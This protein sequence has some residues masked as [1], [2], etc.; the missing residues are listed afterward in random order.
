MS[1]Y[2]HAQ[3]LNIALTGLMASAIQVEA[4]VHAD[5]PVNTTTYADCF[6]RVAM[7]IG[8]IASLQEEVVRIMTDTKQTNVT[9]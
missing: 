3:R 1:L 8:H 4:L 9:Q 7:C 6:E 5:I 2:E